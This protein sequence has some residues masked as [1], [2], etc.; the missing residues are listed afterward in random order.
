MKILLCH[1]IL[2]REITPL[3]EYFSKGDIRKY[4]WRVAGGLGVEIKGSQIPAT[5]LIKVYMT[6]RGGA[7][8]MVVLIYVKKDY[9]LPV[10]AR[11]K[12][13]KIVG[14]NLSKGNPAFQDLLEKNLELIVQDLRDGDFEEM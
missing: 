2:K 5:K 8:R 4:V 7:G 14:T 11:L 13:D 3:L 1:S 10:I 6:S 12:N 9:C